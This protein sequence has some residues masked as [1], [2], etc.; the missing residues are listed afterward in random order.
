M[1]SKGDKRTIPSG[2]TE[3][4]YFYEQTVQ[5]INI[6]LKKVE[7]K[8]DLKDISKNIDILLRK[9]D[10]KADKKEMSSSINILV[11]KLDTHC[12]ILEQ[13]PEFPNEHQQWILH[14]PAEGMN[15]ETYELSI[16]GTDGTIRRLQFT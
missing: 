10:E 4:E 1:R 14:T 16:K 7:Q 9:L 8:Q 13:D 2:M 11:N 3:G 15:P 5:D 6:L 12:P